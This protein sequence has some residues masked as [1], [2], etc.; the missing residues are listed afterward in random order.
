MTQFLMGMNRKQRRSLRSKKPK[1][2]NPGA[3]GKGSPR[4]AMVKGKMVTKNEWRAM[5]K[6]QQK[7]EE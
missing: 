7:T 5:K 4:Y 3:F 2:G 6:A 1:R